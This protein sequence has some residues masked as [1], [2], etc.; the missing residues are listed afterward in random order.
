MFAQGGNFAQDK[1]PKWKICLGQKKLILT[2]DFSLSHHGD[3]GAII[4]MRMIGNFR[5]IKVLN[6]VM[7]CCESL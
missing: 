4:T 1:I 5:V 3:W 6:Q 2:S 7:I